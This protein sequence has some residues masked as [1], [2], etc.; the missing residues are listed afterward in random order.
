MTEEV[1]QLN[2]PKCG[3]LLIRV[4]EVK[5]NHQVNCKWMCINPICRKGLEFPV[6][7]GYTQEDMKEQ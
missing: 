7:Y 4:N 2:C 5:E 1:K 3:E 6:Y